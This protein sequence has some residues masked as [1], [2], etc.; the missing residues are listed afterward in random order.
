MQK[1]SSLTAIVMTAL[2]T[3]LLALALGWGAVEMGLVH[4]SPT[5]TGG[6]GLLLT[7]DVIKHQDKESVIAV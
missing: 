3:L 1:K 5:T 2:F 6:H 4:L 7:N